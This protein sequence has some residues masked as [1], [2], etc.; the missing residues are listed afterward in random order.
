MSTTATNNLEQ[1]IGRKLTWSSLLTQSYGLYR[2]QFW[3]LFRVALLPALL[4]YLWR[5][6]YRTAGHRM[7][8]MGWISSESSG[9][10]LLIV[11]GW[12]NGAFY[13][14]SSSFFFASVAANIVTERGETKPLIS[15]AFT[16]ARA[17][18]GAVSVVALLCW[19]IFWL[20][21]AASAFALWNI[22]HRLRI[23]PSFY[24]SILLVSIPLLLIAGLLSRL[25]LAIPVL[26]NK[27]VAS[28][29]E[30]LQTSVRKTEGWELF[31]IMFLA[32]SAILGFGLYW[33]GNYGLDWLWEHG[34]LNATTYPWVA[35]T[36]YICLA[37]ALESPLF[38]AFSILF[39]ESSL[40]REGRLCAT[41]VE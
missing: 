26:M 28:L 3:T 37:A 34:T 32:K 24:G 13:W 25:A 29:R 35:Q 30:A 4:A 38:I 33:L 20:G 1:P 41:A 36:L 40:P 16:R 2:E 27:P 19:T 31:F 18:I 14:I 5:Y 12:V 21:R 22:L 23:R 9:L 6:V 17:R 15:D 39:R 7:A 8:A 10:A 11:W